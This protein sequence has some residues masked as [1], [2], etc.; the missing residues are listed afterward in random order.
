MK[1]LALALVLVSLLA[2]CFGSFSVSAAGPIDAFTEVEAPA[3]EDQIWS[4]SW[5]HHVGMDIVVDPNGSWSWSANF[6]GNPGCWG[7]NN[8]YTY[9][10]SDNKTVFWN[11]NEDDYSSKGATTVK[12]IV[13]ADFFT[14]SGLGDFGRIKATM[15]DVFDEMTVIYSDDGQNWSTVDFTVAYHTAASTFTTNS[16]AA[17]PV[18]TYWHLIFTEEVPAVTYF[19]F[20]TSESRDWDADDHVPKIGMILNWKYTYLVKGT[21]EAAGGDNT[22]APVTEP[23]TTVAPETD[24]VTTEASAT[25]PVATEAPGAA[26]TEET[27][28]TKADA[29]NDMTWLYIVIAVAVVAVVVIVIVVAKKK[30]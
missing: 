9:L 30:K 11:L 12:E 3:E 6:D 18:D 28:D 4:T 23:E 5:N 15:E 14:Q 8:N 16:G 20:L 26:E 13:F 10:D 25:D 27:D 24:P 22:E 19:G 21:G 17:V 2:A 1:K 29:E 7:M